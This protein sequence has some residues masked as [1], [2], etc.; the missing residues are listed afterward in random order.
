[1][2]DIIELYEQYYDTTRRELRKLGC[3]RFVFDDIYHEVFL[4]FIENKKVHIRMVSDP[5]P[6]I[7]QMCR[8]KWYKERK[9]R[10]VPEFLQDNRVTDGTGNEI[11]SKLLQL[12]EKHMYHLSESC[13]EILE[14]YMM[15]LS[16]HEISR[17]MNLENRNAVKN[18]KYNCK[19][20]LR[21]LVINDPE[22][23]ELY[24]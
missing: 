22:Y 4:L 13:R 17:V 6:Y 24:G 16:E 21:S 10:E 12:I 23:K 14:L 15:G 18:K 7:L 1:M 9:R 20:S 19:L 5:K 3:N 8:Y 11:E 2:D